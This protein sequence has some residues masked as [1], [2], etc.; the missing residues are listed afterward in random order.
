MWGRLTLYAQWLYWLQ[1]SDDLIS[2][3]KFEPPKTQYSTHTCTHVYMHAHTHT[4]MRINQW[5]AGGMRHK[6]FT[7][8]EYSAESS[9][10]SSPTTV[11]QL[12]IYS[13]LNKW[14]KAHNL[15]TSDDLLRISMH[16]TRPV[17]LHGY[18]RCRQLSKSVIWIN[19]E[20]HVVK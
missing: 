4:P 17:S 20:V 16:H 2:V 7:S 3:S 10:V 12:N 8:N 19:R 13:C 9:F 5:E 1:T 11:L 14:N 18:A 6:I 15:N